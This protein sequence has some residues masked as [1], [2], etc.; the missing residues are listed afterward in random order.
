MYRDAPYTL[1]SRNGPDDAPA[2]IGSANERRARNS[3]SESASS[4]ASGSSAHSRRTA[5]RSSGAASASNHH[6]PRPCP[7][8]HKRSEDKA[9]EDKA[10][11]D[12]ADKEAEELRSTLG[13]A[14]DIAPISYHDLDEVF[15]VHGS[16]EDNAPASGH[17][18]QSSRFLDES[19]G[20]N[21][22]A[23]DPNA[24]ISRSIPDGVEERRQDRAT[25]EMDWIAPTLKAV[26]EMELAL[27][28]IRQ[29][30]ELRIRRI[31]IKFVISVIPIVW[32][33]ALLIHVSAYNMNQ[34]RANQDRR[35]QLKF[36]CDFDLLYLINAT[37]GALINGFPQ[38]LRGLLRMERKSLLVPIASV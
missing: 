23:S 29:Q 3:S 9:A 34:R 32:P 38:T 13:G 26:H 14:G 30:L 7:H 28:K 36:N 27:S 8:M 31:E 5:N 10:A 37:T 2:S 18:A 22:P 20:G 19:A 25:D 21:A 11:I 15:R 33:F 24:D 35:K 12:K 6:S 17:P 1:G 4:L 16:V